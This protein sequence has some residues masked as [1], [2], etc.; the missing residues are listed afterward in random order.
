MIQVLSRGYY[1]LIKITPF[2]EKLVLDN[3]CFS[4]S[5]ASELSVIPD[6]CRDEND[7]KAEGNYRLYTVADENKYTEGQHLELQTGCGCWQSYLLP[8]GLPKSKNKH[9]KILNIEERLTVTNNCCQH[10][11]S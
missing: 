8:L 9:V 6:K 4:W 11:S 1:K 5:N 7:I 2:S 3:D 10:S